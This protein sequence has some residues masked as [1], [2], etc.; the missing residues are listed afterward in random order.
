M[1]IRAYG[2]QKDFTGKS[3]KKLD[4]YTHL[5]RATQGLNRCIAVRMD[6]LGAFF[7]SGLAI[8]LVYGPKSSS[9]TTGFT[10][11]MAVGFSMSIMYLVRM[12]NEFEVQCNRYALTYNLTSS[13]T[14]LT[15]LERIQDYIDIEHE[16]NATEAGNPPAYWPSAGD[17][18]VEKLSARYSEVGGIPSLVV[19][20]CK[21]Y[22]S[23]DQKYYTI[24]LSTSSR[25]NVLAL[26]SLG[27]FFM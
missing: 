7:S 15:S 8:Y 16:P 20:L 11:N 26:V 24:Y 12:Y 1:S 9:L 27:V 10:L 19:A 25:A 17:L 22:S 23:L 21:P 6:A 13:L 2:A 14:S 4:Y 18:R 5:T 3:I